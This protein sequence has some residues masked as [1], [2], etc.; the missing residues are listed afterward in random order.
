MEFDPYDLFMKDLS[1]QNVIARC[2]S[3][4]PLYTMC[5]PSRSALHHVL[6][7]LLP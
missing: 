3:S 1:S 7:L 2:N 4:G 5:L 6:L